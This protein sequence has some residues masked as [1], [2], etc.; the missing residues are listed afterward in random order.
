MVDN[1]ASGYV[2]K[3]ATKKELL[4]AIN[5]V[6][7]GHTYFSVEAADSLRESDAQH[8]MITRREKEVYN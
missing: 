2:L 7:K 3:N 6:L 8:P 4:E 1:G 5:V